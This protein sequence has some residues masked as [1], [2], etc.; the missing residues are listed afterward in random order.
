M[1]AHL[2]VT[3]ADSTSQS[4]QGSLLSVITPRS[5][6]SYA[7]LGQV[8]TMDLISFAYQIASGMVSTYVLV[9]LALSLSLVHIILSYRST[10][11]D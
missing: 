4:Y 11:L 2:S 6:S 8:E 10:Y 9:C 7:K 1:D 3:T 5:N